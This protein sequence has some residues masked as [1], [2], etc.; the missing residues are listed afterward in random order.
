MT[1]WDEHVVR[2][3][4]CQ[5]CPLGRQRG[6]ICLARGVVPCD[7]LF[8]GEAPGPSEDALGRPFVGPAGALLDQMI[9]RSL[10]D[11]VSHSLTNIVAC[12]PAEAKARG[13][14]EPE[15][16]E[17]RACSPRLAEFVNICQPRLIVCVGGLAAAYVDH[18][19]TVPCTDIVHPA[20]ILRHKLAKKQQEVQHAIVVL[21]CAVDSMLSSPRTDFKQW[22]NRRAR[23]KA[24]DDSDIPF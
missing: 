4:D 9:E 3:K 5:K 2:W 21:R 24:Y 16:D 19:D 7:V 13:D 6:R 22:G 20:W 18:G 12:Y 14:N 10:P 8:V 17:I 11:L 15:S 23:V 1:D